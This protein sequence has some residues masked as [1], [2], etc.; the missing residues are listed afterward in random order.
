MTD[1][2]FAAL[3]LLVTLAYGVIAL[4]AIKAPFQYDPLGPE[5]WPQ[6]I[7]AVMFLALV[8]LMWRPTATRFAV[9]G[10]GWMRL[11]VMLA[12]LSAYALAF[13]PLGFVLS[14]FFFS[15]L[16]ARSLGAAWR[17]AVPFGLGMG[18]GGYVLCAGLLELN[19][20]AGPLPG[21]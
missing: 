21:L 5:S 20:P 4:T 13:Q 18:L 1:R 17:G 10:P 12:L 7:A 16:A 3:M 11:G 19:L 14:T 8:L 15:A 9:D 2:V 6:L